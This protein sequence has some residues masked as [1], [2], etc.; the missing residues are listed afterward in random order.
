MPIIE[1]HIL[2]GYDP[3][4]R[5]RLAHGLTDA[6]RLVIPAPPESITV[7]VHELARENYMRGG[8]LRRRGVALPD[9]ADVV[10][11]FHNAI[12]TGD[13][14][15]AEAFMTKDG[16]FVVPGGARVDKP[17]DVAAFTASRWTEISVTV[18]STDVCPGPEGPI[19]FLRT[20]INGTLR[21]GTRR[22][23]LRSIQRFQ[24][25][26]PLIARIDAISDLPEPQPTQGP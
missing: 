26:G 6:L 1:A 9:A 11:R 10:R 3:G 12:T 17:H 22:E 5:T 19:V 7:V 21:D 25:S 24:F 15:A 20:R 8:A 2:H 14:D 13:Y 18:D 23:G 16:F 4:T